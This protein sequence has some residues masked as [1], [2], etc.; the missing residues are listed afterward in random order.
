MAPLF[1]KLRGHFAEFLNNASPVGLRLSASSTCVGLRYGS[2]NSY[3]GFSRQCFQLLPYL[4]SVRITCLVPVRGFSSLPPRMLAPAFHCR[5]RLQPC[6]PAVLC[7]R[8]TG[9]STCPPSPTRLRLGLGPGLPRVDQLYPGNLGYPAW[10][11]P[12]SI[13]LLIPAFSL[14]G[15]PPLL[16]GAASPFHQCSPTSRWY[17]RV[18]PTPWLRWR[19]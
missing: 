17:P 16:A 2:G 10:M 5:L 11:I 14:H 7:H 19:V 1:P 15:S 12:T 9:F 4:I 8:S 6:V 18:S 13:S 3:S